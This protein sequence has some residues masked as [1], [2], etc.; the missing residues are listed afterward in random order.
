MDRAKLMVAIL[1]HLNRKQTLCLKLLNEQPT[2]YQQ[3]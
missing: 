3:Q 2:Y 1:N